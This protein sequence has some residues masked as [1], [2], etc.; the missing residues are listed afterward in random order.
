[1]GAS[2]KRPISSPGE[3][4]VSPNDEILFWTKGLSS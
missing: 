1:M 3:R 2:P 4:A